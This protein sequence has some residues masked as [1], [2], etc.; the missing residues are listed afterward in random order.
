MSTNLMILH[1]YILVKVS[2]PGQGQSS[3]GCS[4]AQSVLLACSKEC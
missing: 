3:A 2:S 1:S 4:P